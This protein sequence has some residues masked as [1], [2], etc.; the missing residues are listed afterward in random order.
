MN[1]NGTKYAGDRKPSK[2][3]KS[4]EFNALAKK[5]GAIPIL[6]ALVTLEPE[7]E[8]F[9][10]KDARMPL[11]E[12]DVRD[13]YDGAK[14][15]SC[16][17]IPNNLCI[18][19]PFRSDH[20]LGSCIVDRRKNTWTDYN[21]SVG[22]CNHT[23]VD[24][25][26]RFFCFWDDAWDKYPASEAIKLIKEKI[27]SAEIA[28]IIAKSI[29]DSPYAKEAG[30]EKLRKDTYVAY[31]NGV[32]SLAYRFNLIT[33][34]EYEHSI[35][36][37]PDASP[38]VFSGYDEVK[39][40]KATKGQSRPQPQIAS[41]FVV[42]LTLTALAEVRHGALTKNQLFELNRN[43][44]LHETEDYFAFPRRGEGFQVC[45][46]IQRWTASWFAQKAYKKKV[47]NLTPE[48]K[49]KL[50]SSK[51]VQLFQK[52]VENVPG[53]YRDA[54]GMLLMSERQNGGIGILYHDDKGLANGVQ[55][56]KSDK[57]DG[58]KYA[59]L[60]SSW[61]LSYPSYKGGASSGTPC[62]YLEN[63]NPNINPKICIT[64][65]RFKAEKIADTL[66]DV[67]FVS[68]VST[69][70]KGGVIDMIE[71]VKG[72]RNEVYIMFDADL[73][74]NTSVHGNLVNL[75]RAI[76][77]QGMIPYMII[78]PKSRGKGYDDLLQSCGTAGYAAYLKT[79]KF[80]EFE[81]AYQRIVGSLMTRAGITTLTGQKKEVLDKF[82][83]TTQACLEAYFKLKKD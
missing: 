29:P 14:S 80:D 46:E 44:G 45:Q 4:A 10:N 65:G 77:G 52:E 82:S 12:G 57:D 69:W 66:G 64:E 74:S 41:P 23:V 55:I 24:F 43:R 73:M 31:K 22:A 25:E 60:S 9:L 3:Q 13:M 42:H 39:V 47:A 1:N 20:N 38:R 30:V 15:G 32:Y 61:T 17:R 7:V 28:A 49:V 62:G 70:E 33:A 48:E 2:Y 18:R 75:A 11:S 79:M 54:R 68:G 78:W 59:W 37:K 36:K 34:E 53:F 19:N 6:L 35:S 71:R 26:E 8:I 40:E 58:P 81:D 72:V 50:S 16:L 67:I 56:R 21:W 51:L 63:R 5:V 83:R 27:S 76:S